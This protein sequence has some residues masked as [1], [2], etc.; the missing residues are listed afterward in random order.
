MEEGTSAEG[1]KGL[2][3]VTALV[4]IPVHAIV[5]NIGDYKT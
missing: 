1:V 5:P 3:C 4:T 2:V